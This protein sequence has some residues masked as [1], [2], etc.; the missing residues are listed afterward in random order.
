M[1]DPSKRPRRASLLLAINTTMPRQGWE[2]SQPEARGRL[3]VTPQVL[4][5]IFLELEKSAWAPT[6]KARFW[7]VCTLLFAGA[8][9]YGSAR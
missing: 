9:R 6:K 7:V 1:F 2:H 3:A 4:R 5:S 8:L